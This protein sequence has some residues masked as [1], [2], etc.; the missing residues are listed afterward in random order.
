MGQIQ[1]SELGSKW[2]LLTSIDS[3]ML[4]ELSRDTS[5][6]VSQSMF[7]SDFV[8]TGMPRC[9]SKGLYALQSSQVGLTS[10]IQN[11]LL[12]LKHQVLLPV[13]GRLSLQ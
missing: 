9:A 8:V 2:H 4:S 13:I 10:A 7:L 6:S 11:L 3:E 5:M 12:E 1:V